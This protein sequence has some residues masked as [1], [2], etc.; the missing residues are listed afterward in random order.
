MYRTLIHVD[1][2]NLEQVG[3]SRKRKLKKNYSCVSEN[4]VEYLRSNGKGKYI[5]TELVEMKESNGNK[6]ESGEK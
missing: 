3:E 6:L 4:T 5:S 1:N 2:I